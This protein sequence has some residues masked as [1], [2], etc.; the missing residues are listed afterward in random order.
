VDLEAL[1]AVFRLD[2]AI[3]AGISQRAIRRLHA[4]G[5]LDQLG[6]GVYAV[7]GAVDPALAPLA[8]AALCRPSATLCLGSAL[9]RYGLSDEIPASQDIALP[10]NT[11]SPAGF[12]HVTWHRFAQE[13][14]EIGRVELS[15]G[16]INAATYSPER[17]IIDIFRLSYREGEDTAVEALKRWLRRPGNHPSSLL[18][19]ADGFPA[20]RHR[21]RRI[22]EILV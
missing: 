2:Q 5:D 20:V 17:T 12:A 7:P 15:I 16:G 1:P 18:T 6:R 11:R 19:M 3:A 4:A 13:T 14:F 22:L 9:A 10:R 8:G 21:L